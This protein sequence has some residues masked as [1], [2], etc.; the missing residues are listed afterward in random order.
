MPNPAR[1]APKGMSN[2]DKEAEMKPAISNMWV[3]V[4]GISRKT[5]QAILNVFDGS[6]VGFLREQG[7]IGPQLEGAMANSRLSVE[8]TLPIYSNLAFAEDCLS[9]IM[10]PIGVYAANNGSWRTLNLSP[11]M[12]VLKPVAQCYAAAFTAY[13]P[14]ESLTKGNLLDFIDTYTR[15][16]KGFFS[17]D[18]EETRHLSIK[19]CRIASILIQDGGL[20]DDYLDGVLTPLF[21]KSVQLTGTKHDVTKLSAIIQ[22]YFDTMRYVPGSASSQD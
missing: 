1:Y 8:E 14:F 3:T 6:A 9:A 7:V 4:Q 2:R 20:V 17:I 19:L 16:D 11:L 10:Q 5:N 13:R 18:F 21:N 22:R 15:I 12:P